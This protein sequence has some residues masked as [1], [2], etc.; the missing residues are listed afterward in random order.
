M[1][2]IEGLTKLEVVDEM[3][4]EVFAQSEEGVVDAMLTLTHPDHCFGR[5]YVPDSICE[6]DCDATAHFHGKPVKINTLCRQ[7]CSGNPKINDVAALY[8]TPRSGSYYVIKALIHL[9]EATR[10]EIAEQ[11]Q[12]FAQI[13]GS[14][15]TDLRDRVD[16]TLAVMHTAD[17]PRVRK[18]GRGKTAI[19]SLDRDRE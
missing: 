3:E 5:E 9:G 12:Q 14:D 17:P 7:L 8:F 16:R 13:D 18:S 15:K 6:E 2:E 11:A 19:Y 1:E 10:E 4:I